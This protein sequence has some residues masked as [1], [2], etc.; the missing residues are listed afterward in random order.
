MRF[1]VQPTSPMLFRLRPCPRLL[2]T[3]ALLLGTAGCGI[4]DPE[5]G[6]K[7]PEVV[8]ML[9]MGSSYLD[10]HNVP[11][12]VKAF[13]EASG[14]EVVLGTRIYAGVG[15]ENFAR[16]TTAAAMIRDGEWDFVVLQGGAAGAAFPEEMDNSLY[17][18]LE[19]LRQKT[20]AASTETRVVYMMPWA[21]E[22][23]MTWMEGRN[24]TYE[25]MQL[26]I[27][28]NTVHWAQALDMV[29]APVG[30][31]WYRV[32]TTWDPPEHYLHMQDMSHASYLGGYLTAAT[33]F[34][35]M[36]G[37]SS[38]ESSYDG[39]VEHG[40]ARALREVASATVMDSLGLWRVLR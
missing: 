14:R 26:A 39:D 34:S 28:E 1:S 17:L 5:D 23:G 10:D 15:L 4:L 8:R 7:D 19:N 40:L 30:M 2:I 3:V 9:F 37:E 25:I 18:A 24:E 21:Y 11:Y 27:R 20:A 29:L 13:A 35:T 32:L 36:F 22:D 16:D 31:A 38:V 33:F 6:E 12:Q